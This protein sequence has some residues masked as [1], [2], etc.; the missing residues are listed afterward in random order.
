[1]RDELKALRAKTEARRCDDRGESATTGGGKINDRGRYLVLD[2][3]KK[4]WVH[5]MAS[6]EFGESDSDRGQKGNL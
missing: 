5:K 1:M 4:S 6:S 3:R 2:P